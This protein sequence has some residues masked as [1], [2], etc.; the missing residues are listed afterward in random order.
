MPQ[1]TLP[2]IFELN[3]IESVN[4]LAKV[5]NGFLHS[6]NWWVEPNYKHKSIYLFNANG[7]PQLTNASK[8]DICKCIL[9][10]EKR[11]TLDGL[12]RSIFDSDGSF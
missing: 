5:L 6:I 11:R 9:R 2:S 4:D 1:A 3:K 8:E 10:M 12:H 7:D